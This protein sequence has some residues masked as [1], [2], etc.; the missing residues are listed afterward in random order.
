MED[1]LTR[2]SLI[3]RNRDEGVLESKGVGTRSSAATAE[4]PSLLHV[5]RGSPLA[6]GVVDLNVGRSERGKSRQNEEGV[7]LGR[8]QV[9][10]LSKLGRRVD[11]R[12]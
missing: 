9:R 3:S 8:K 11:G 7:H 6:E 12:R 10:M 1:E 4:S 2:L 5:L